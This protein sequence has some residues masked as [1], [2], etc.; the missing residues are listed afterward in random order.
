M[1]DTPKLSALQAEAEQNRL[2]F[3]QTDLA[4]CFTFADLVRTELGWGDREAAQRVLAKAE[5]GYATIERFLPEVE[6]AEQRQELERK[7]NDLRTT[8]DGVQ[9]ELQPSTRDSHNRP[10]TKEGVS[11]SSDSRS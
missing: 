10:F 6:N 4:L 2:H 7:L 11:R 8:L 5:D 9:R 3:L 1:G